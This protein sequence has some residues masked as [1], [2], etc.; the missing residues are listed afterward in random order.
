M[1][2]FNNNN[3]FKIAQFNPIEGNGSNQPI[4][5][6]EFKKLPANYQFTFDVAIVGLVIG[7]TYQ[8]NLKIKDNSN[9]IIV[10]DDI[11]MDTSHFLFPS[12]KII[13]PGIGATS[14]TLTTPSFT[15]ADMD[16]NTYGAY[17]SLIDKDGI[18][19]DQSHTVFFVKKENMPNV[20][21]LE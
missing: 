7:N 16:N 12:N 14:L 2:A 13:V 4:F 19:L 21:H 9:S 1:T 20:V 10:N 8:L 6:F 17:L 11:S 5:I 15:V 18:E 3:I